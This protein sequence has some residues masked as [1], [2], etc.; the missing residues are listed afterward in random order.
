MERLTLSRATS[1]SSSR[2]ALD[3]AAGGVRKRAS[4]LRRAGDAV[5]TSAQLDFSGR[6]NASQRLLRARVDR[7]DALVDML[8]A[9][10]ATLEPNEIADLIVERASMWMPASGWAV[11]SADASGQLTVLAGRGVTEHNEAD[12]RAVAR[13]VMDRRADFSSE[14]LS[15]DPRVGGQTIGAVLALP[16]PGR[17]HRVCALVAFDRAAASQ[18]PRLAPRV[19]ESVT[20]L[21]EPASMALDSAVMLKRAEELSVTDDLTQLYNSR[22]LNLVLRRETKRAS[23]SGRPLSLLF[24]DLDGFKGVND[25]HGHLYGSRALVEASGLIRGSARETDVVSRFGGDEFAIVLPD[26]GGEGAYAVGERVRD[27]VAAHPFLAGDGLNIHLTASVGVAT[28][29]DVAASADE[30]IAA[31]D[32]AMYAVKDSGKNGIQAASAPADN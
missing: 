18:K 14:D 17:E 29:P 4:K 20:L 30:L 21:L 1:V 12:V 27:R 22:Y 26:T 7:R 25:T 16:L 24:I 5:L 23:R 10:N 13:W 15:G 8:R 32:K 2:R 3:Q 28:L 11:V 9:V 31:A 19:L 6:L